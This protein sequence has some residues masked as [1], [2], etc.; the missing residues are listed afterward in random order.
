VARTLTA[1]ARHESEHKA[2]RQKAQIIEAAK[3]GRR[4]G[5]CPYG[6][7]SPEEAEVVREMVARLLA[8]DSLRSIALDLNARGIATVR[9]GEWSVQQ[10]KQ[11]AA[12]ASNA[13]LRTHRGAV[14]ADGQWPALIS[15]DDHERVVRLLSDPAR[16]TARHGR[17]HL[18]SGIARCGRCGGAMRH[19][20]SNGRDIYK[21][22]RLDVSASSEPV[23]TFILELVNRRLNADDASA[24]RE[25][26][27]EAYDALSSRLAALR[28]RLD[29]LAEDYADG[30]LDR[31]QV[32]VAGDRLRAEMAEVENRM[33]EAERRDAAIR[34]RGVDIYSLTVERQR[35]L[36]R[37]LLTV[38]VL[39]A[40]R[41]GAA[42]HDFDYG[43][44]RIT[45]L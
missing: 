38:E 29:G 37:G 24:V 30:L 1:W 25:P 18:L 11:V 42:A 41:R 9:G 7:R 32:R 12:R 14:V 22:E 16:K 26:G 28:G 6:W 39:P 43:R 35:A 44:L 13:G 33:R 45:W 17:R 31:D 36:L 40:T 19:A 34:A 5:F 15:T 27:S 10:V 4:H 3:S 21:C 23:E 2:N 8:G 20:S